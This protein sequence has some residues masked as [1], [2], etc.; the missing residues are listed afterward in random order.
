MYA[1]N[2]GGCIM[3]VFLFPNTYN[4]IKP[5]MVTQVSF[6]GLLVFL[7][8]MFCGC[9]NSNN[10]LDASNQDLIGN[11]P[12]N[13]KL[14]NSTALSWS[15]SDPLL[16]TG[17]CITDTENLQA[18]IHHANMDGGG[19][20]YLGPG[21]FYVCE[22]IVRHSGD[23]GDFG[24]NP[25]PFNGT[26]QGAG[27]GVTIIK[28]IRGPGDAPFTT[29]FGLPITF[30][31]WSLDYFGV[32]DL[33][34]EAD[35]EIADEWDIGYGPTK[36][37]LSYCNLGGGRRGVGN[38]LGTDCVNV[39]F[40]GSLD[41]N[42]DPE[43]D[44]MFEVFGGGGGGTHNAKSCE[45]ENGRLLMLEYAALGNTT[46]NIGG[47]P[48]EKLTFTN[49]TAGIQG[50][51]VSSWNSADI[52]LN[53]SY[54]ETNN[55]AGGLW[56]STHRTNTMSNITVNHNMID[57]I[58]DSW[59]AG[60]EIW[61]KNRGV[62]NTV[63]SNNKIH[64]SNASVIGPIVFAGVD[65]G[66]I[67]NNKFTGWGPVAINVGFF[68]YPG[69]VTLVGNNLQTWETTENPWVDDLYAPI[70]FGPNI[71]NSVVVGG[72]N[73][74]NIWDLGDG[75]TYTGVNNA[76][77]NIGQTVKDAMQQKAEAMKAMRSY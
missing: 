8:L 44:L 14:G 36:G 15:P 73:K 23:P 70:W 9:E 35:S 47:S 60:V 12:Q 53:L 45:F 6:I 66:L 13:F 20:L 40:K 49:T 5:N 46:I 72:N 64:N 52:N 24:Y 54:I 65:N 1:Y 33:T 17:D 61:A 62:V 3:K 19:T 18:A 10:S 75:N 29:F 55:T 21:T 57:M 32:R 11:A 28:S 2:N 69:S 7:C 58:E 43:I 67:S 34:F 37:L 71:T 50:Q 77:Q 74:E 30:A 31:I 48:K 39:H 27:K 16:P 26:I 68:D 63:I 51:A 41:S 25:V 42:G 56:H 4:S 22:S 38:A 59:S 76:Q